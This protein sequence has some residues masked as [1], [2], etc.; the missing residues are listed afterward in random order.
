[1]ELKFNLSGTVTVSSDLE[2]ERS[3]QLTPVNFHR[4]H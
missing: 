3:I 2:H 1:M 4:E